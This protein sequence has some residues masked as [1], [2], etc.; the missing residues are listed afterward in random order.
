LSPIPAPDSDPAGLSG[1]QV[2]IGPPLVGVPQV[3]G[4]IAR[5]FLHAARPN[6]FGTAT[7]RGV[8]YVRMR[9]NGLIESRTIVRLR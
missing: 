5:T 2:L 9:A 4:A 8:Y 6:P 1:I 3:G 7:E